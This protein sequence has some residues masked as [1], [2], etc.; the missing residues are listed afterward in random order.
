MHF[1]CKAYRNLTYRRITMSLEDAIKENTAAIEKLIAALGKG[2]SANT[3]AHTDDGDDDAPA[4]AR[5]GR[6]PKEATAAEKPKF[7]A[8]Q[9][10]AAAQKVKAE[11]GM[12]T[13]RE[14]YAEFGIETI[15]ELKSVD[16]DGFVA[17]ADKALADGDGD[18]GGDL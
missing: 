1:R 3:A 18:D 2:A 15:T 14:I 13:L 8:D 6:K 5:R 7:T 17:A 9:V 10:K 12:S 16:F 11:K 4:P